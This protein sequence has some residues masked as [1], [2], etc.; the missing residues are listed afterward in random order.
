M[1]VAPRTPA[2]VIG[3]K[4]TVLPSGV[5]ARFNSRRSVETIEGAKSL[6]VAP[7]G[8]WPRNG[9][10]G[11]VTGARAVAPRDSR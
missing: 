11:F 2:S 5:K 9:P 1:S 6:A 8:V 7:G 4:N 3:G 10:V